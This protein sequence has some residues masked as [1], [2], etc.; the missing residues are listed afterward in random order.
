[1]PWHLISP[2]T[3][4]VACCAAVGAKRASGSSKRENTGAVSSDAASST[5]AP[6][7]PVTG[8]L[9]PAE[10]GPAPASSAALAAPPASSSEGEGPCRRS[11]AA[12]FEGLGGLGKD[13]WAGRDGHGVSGPRNAR[14]NERPAWRTRMSPAASS[15][16]T[17]ASGVGEGKA[18]GPS[19]TRRYDEPGPAGPCSASAIVPPAPSHAWVDEDRFAVSRGGQGRRIVSGTRFALGLLRRL[20]RRLHLLQ[21]LRLRWRQQVHGS[22][23]GVSIACLTRLQGCEAPWR[24]PGTCLDGLRHASPPSGRNFLHKVYH[25]DF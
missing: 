24:V 21:K 23:E 17:A 12:A 20:D 14:R 8:A 25:G 11:L 18:H 16:G 13:A 22:S 15:Q 5:P 2:D 4:R 7:M 6:S 19:A 1:M 10:L 3:R 9:T